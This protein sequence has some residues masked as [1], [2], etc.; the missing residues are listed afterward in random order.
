MHTPEGLTSQQR[1]Q[2]QLCSSPDTRA[3]PQPQA[4][5]PKTQAMVLGK[6]GTRAH[7]I[8]HSSNVSV[9]E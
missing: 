8:P 3:Q 5:H 9:L 6:P 1:P 4:V 2:S 7:G